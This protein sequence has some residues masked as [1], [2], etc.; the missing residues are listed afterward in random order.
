MSNELVDP[1]FPVLW[2]EMAASASGRLSSSSWLL[3]SGRRKEKETTGTVK[4]AR[5]RFRGQ[6]G[7]VVDSQ[8]ELSDEPF[9]A[10]AARGG[11]GLQPLRRGVT[12]LPVWHLL[13]GEAGRSRVLG[14]VLIPAGQ[15]PTSSYQEV[16]KDAEA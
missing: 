6:N 14:R 5:W 1:D 7:A 13:C 3:H 10:V 15:N 16:H 2:E 4:A 12:L 11:F 9:P 8:A